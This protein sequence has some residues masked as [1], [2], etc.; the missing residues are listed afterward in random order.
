MEDEIVIVYGN[1]P[2]WHHALPYSS[3]LFR[4]ASLF[5]QLKHDVI[6]LFGKKWAVVS[7][8]WEGFD[9]RGILNLQGLVEL[10]QK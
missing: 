4:H 8:Q 9:R 1:Y 2:D 10:E 3:K 7:S 6:E 5:K